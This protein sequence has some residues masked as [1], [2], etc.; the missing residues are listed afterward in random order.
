ML[1]AQL[2]RM[3]EVTAALWTDRNPA[4][5]LADATTYLE[6]VGHVVVAWLWL[7]VELVATGDGAFYAGKRLA[8]EYFFTRE[9]PRVDAMFDVLAAQDNLYVNLDEAV[10]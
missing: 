8:A 3:L 10:F 9:L 4:S 1:A 2:Q 6:A 7:D 5:A